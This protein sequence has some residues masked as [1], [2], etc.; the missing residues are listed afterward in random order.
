VLAEIINACLLRR[1]FV[2]FRIEKTGGVWYE[3]HNP[4]MASATR[5][6]VELA[7]PIE[8][9]NQ[10]FVM[11]AMVHVVSVEILLPVPEG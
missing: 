7:L 9:G 11:I 1:P 10:R 8:N 6:A 2:P 3:V 5:H 4:A